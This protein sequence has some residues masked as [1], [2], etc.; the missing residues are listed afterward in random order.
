MPRAGLSPELVTERAGQLIDERGAETLT[1]ADL[2]ESLGVRVPS[3]YKHIDGM[4]AIQRGVML[5]AKVDLRNALAEAAVGKSRDDAIAAMSNAYR[6]WALA[7]PGQ[8]PMTSHAPAPGDDDDLA[9]S[10]ALTEVIFAVLGGYELRGDDAVDATRFLRSALHGFVAL[11]TSGGF[12]LPVDLERSFV[13]LVESVIT[14]LSSWSP[15]E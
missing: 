11:E 14:A 1:L 5:A 4:P 7:H 3:L 10:T 13:R 12:G 6:R 8:Y 2:A 9:A 15:S